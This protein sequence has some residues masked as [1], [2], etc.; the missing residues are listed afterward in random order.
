MSSKRKENK[1]SE[2]I[3]N[4]EGK[5]ENEKDEKNPKKEEDSN[6]NDPNYIEL[7]EMEKS[8]NGPSIDLDYE[9]K[10]YEQ[11][12]SQI[13]TTEKDSPKNKDN[14]LE[15]NPQEK[16]K[17]LIGN[18]KIIRIASSKCSNQMKKGQKKK[19]KANICKNAN[20]LKN[21]NIH[22]KIIIGKNEK[23]IRRII[24][25][26]A[27]KPIKTFEFLDF[28]MSLEDYCPN[29]NNDDDDDERLSDKDLEILSQISTNKGFRRN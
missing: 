5:K 7:C 20:I 26:R 9:A 16:S 22:K 10:E 28:I 11:K 14:K 17:N 25:N 23:K 6:K 8:E 29:G 1:Q 19:K 24:F 3:R 15:N 13:I 27:L 12:E 4:E 18:S 2:P 21:V